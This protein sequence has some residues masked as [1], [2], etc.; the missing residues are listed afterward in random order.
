MVVRH[1]RVVECTQRLTATP[2]VDLG[3][4]VV[5]PGL[6]NAHTHLEFSG[7]RSPLPAGPNFPAW[8]SQ[9]VRYRRDVLEAAAATSGPTAANGALREPLQLGL[10]ECFASGTAVV[11]DI[12]N[13]PW[14]IDCFPGSQALASGAAAAANRR[15]QAGLAVAASDWRAHMGRVAFPRVV[16]I[17]EMLGLSPQRLEESWQWARGE[18]FPVGSPHELLLV[19]GLSP[20]A[21]YSIHFPTLERLLSGLRRHTLLAMHLAESSAELEWIASQ[22][23]PFA[24]AFQRLGVEATAPPP[25]ISQCIALLARQQRALLVHG[26]YL[27]AAEIA[28][29]ASAPGM[30][31]VFCPRTHAHFG[32]AAYPLRALQA[33]GVPVILGTDSRASNPDL[34]LWDEVVWVKQQFPELSGQQL[35]EKVTTAPARALGIEWEVGQLRPGHWAYAVIAPAQ[36]HWT[37]E[38]VLDELCQLSARDLGLTPLSMIAGW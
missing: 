3:E 34:S 28:Q 9:V 24:E 31:V 17:A 13:R 38:N 16:A 22:T 7:L 6:V 2:D 12:L 18:V 36:D 25:T 10:Q 35:L 4:S 30:S 33:A 15:P 27:S 20:H 19:S 5:L 1:G 14:Q 32:H 21:P 26:N 37:A 23:G 11:A 8:V 29:V